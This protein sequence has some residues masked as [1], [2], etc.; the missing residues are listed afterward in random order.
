M[1]EIEDKTRDEIENVGSGGFEAE[2]N[3]LTEFERKRRRRT[4]GW[5]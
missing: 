2:E 1:D 3:R 5:F 4:S